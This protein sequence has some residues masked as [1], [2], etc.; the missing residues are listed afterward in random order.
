MAVGLLFKTKQEA[1]KHVREGM[2]GENEGE[3]KD[4]EGDNKGEG[5]GRMRGAPKV[6]TKG[7]GVVVHACPRM[8]QVG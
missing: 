8:T 6:E 5:G 1:S 4:D 7:G 2:E 3:D